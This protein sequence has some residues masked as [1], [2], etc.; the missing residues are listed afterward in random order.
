MKDFQTLTSITDRFCLKGEVRSVEPYGEGHINRTYLVTTL[1]GRYILQTINHRLFTDVPALMRNIE[2]VTSFVRRAVVQQNGDP[3]REC[4]NLILTRE[5]NT[6]YFDGSEYYR[7]YQFIEDATSYQIVKD[8]AVFFESAVAFGRFADLLA[9]F[10]ASQLTEILPGFH[11]TRKRYRDFSASLARDEKK[12]AAE[13]RP[14]IEWVQARE[15]RC[16]E[17]V[18][19]L[20]NGKMPLRVTHNDTKLNNVMIDNR[21]KK[22]LAVIDLDTVMP[23]SLCYDFGDSI[24]FGCNSAAEDEPDLDRVHFRMDLFESYTRGY[25]SALY[26]SITETE[27]EHLAKASF[28]MTYE[29][30]MRFLADYL[31]GDVYFRTARPAHNLDRARVQFRLASEMEQRADE[32]NAIVRNVYAEC[33]K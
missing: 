30:G 15:H 4:L 28:L 19:L 24:R 2:L 12:R 25:L 20:E 18:S 3:D 6:F 9:G 31:D 8:P 23:G 26:R 16:G 10:D 13:V 11:D 17:L 5:G 32:M 14:E 21:T 33:K 27:L 29:C 7:V 22:A 1:E